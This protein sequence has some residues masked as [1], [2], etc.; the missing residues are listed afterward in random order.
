MKPG[1]VKKVIT[2]SL[3]FL[4]FFIP[5]YSLEDIKVV[6]LINLEDISATFEEEKDEL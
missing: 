6:P 4:F 2:I 3:L 5:S 1:I